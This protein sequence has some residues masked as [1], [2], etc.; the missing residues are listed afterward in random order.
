[1]REVNVFRP[2]TLG[3]APVE[4]RLHFDVRVDFAAAIA[5]GIGGPVRSGV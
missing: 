5:R 3:F 1:L 4:H 2:R